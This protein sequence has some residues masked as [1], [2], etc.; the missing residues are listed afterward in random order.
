MLKVVLL[1]AL[2]LCC[3]W[4]TAANDPTPKRTEDSNFPSDAATDVS[5]MPSGS[6]GE[7]V[8][9]SDADG[10]CDYKISIARS[11][12]STEAA[13]ISSTLVKPSDSADIKVARSETRQQDDS[14][15]AVYAFSIV[16]GLLF[17]VAQIVCTAPE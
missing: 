15:L 3:V 17:V 7:C 5:K 10:C 12:W 16:F 14:I 9:P 8:V 11:A 6:A 13:E 2:V 1:F 4:T